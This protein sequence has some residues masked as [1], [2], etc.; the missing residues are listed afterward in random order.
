MATHFIRKGANRGATVEGRG[1]RDFALKNCAV[2]TEGSQAQ[3]RSAAWE[4][5]RGARWR[6]QKK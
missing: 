5:S 6:I 3:Q 4:H 1:F 2:V